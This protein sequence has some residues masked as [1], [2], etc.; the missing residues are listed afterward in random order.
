M[1]LPLYTPT[2]AGTFFPGGRAQI[3]LTGPGA[4]AGL[5][6][7][8]WH[9]S[10]GAQGVVHADGWGDI[11]TPPTKNVWWQSAGR[12]GAKWLGAVVS[13]REFDLPIHIAD[14]D[15]ADWPTVY[16]R[17][18]QDIDHEHPARLHIVTP[19]GYTMLDVRLGDG[20]ISHE[21]VHDPALEGIETFAVPLVAEQ[22]YYT[23][24]EDTHTWTPGRTP[25]PVRNRGD[26]PAWPV[27][28][29]KGPGM[30]QLPDGNGHNTVTLPAA[31]EEGQVARVNTDP[32][33]RRV[34][35]NDGEKLWPL[36]GPQRFRHPV[37]AGGM[38]KLGNLRMHGA[39]D[40]SSIT[41]IITP[42][43]RTPWRPAHGL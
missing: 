2:T 22:P 34:V 24:I 19:A 32:D 38:L 13:P 21:Y 27:Y 8:A 14:T 41:A 26:R 6:E 23:G 5:P 11:D 25:R 10:T 4:P 43:W 3:I 17:L 12:P 20:G 1:T 7:R 9:L 42:R 40:A 33:E 18:M 16:A 15:R 28:I 29:V 39:T 37:P 31:L 36:V 30:P 35:V